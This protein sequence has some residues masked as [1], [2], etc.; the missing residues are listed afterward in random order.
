MQIDSLDYRNNPW[1]LTMRGQEILKINA[2]VFKGDP[3]ANDPCHTHLL[4]KMKLW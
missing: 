1:L 2:V 4:Q 3:E